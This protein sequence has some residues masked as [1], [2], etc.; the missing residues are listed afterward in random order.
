MKSY[1]K[2]FIIGFFFISCKTGNL[3]VIAE[4]PTSL[5]ETSAIEQING[6]D[7]LW[8]IEDSGNSNHLYGLNYDGKIIKDLRV[9]NAE[10]IDWEDLTSDSEGYIYIGDFGNN[11]GKRKTYMIYKIPIVENSE[12]SVKAKFIQFTLPK[13]IDSL[14][15]ESFFVHNDFFYLFS[16]NSKTCKLFK[17]PNKVGN[18]EAAYVSKIKLKGKHNKVTSADISEDG[19]TVVLLNHDK[20]WKL[21]EYSGD[22]FFSGN[23]DALEFDHNSQKEGINLMNNNEVLITDERNKYDGGNIYK[24]K[25]ESRSN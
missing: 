10:N 7:L 8:V 15:F 13:D 12:R 24:Y 23:I 19:K 11:D 4:I 14:D 1:I 25:L 5:K 20:L 3:E 6:S 22:D 17:I 21:T 16:K 18:H 2:L 9:L